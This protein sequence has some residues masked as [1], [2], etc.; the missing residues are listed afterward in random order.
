MERQAAGFGSGLRR[1]GDRFHRRNWVR[2]K[3]DGWRQ[4]KQFRHKI[5][6]G[7]KR[8]KPNPHERDLK[9]KREELARVLERLQDPDVRPGMARAVENG[10]KRAEG[11]SGLPCALI[12]QPARSPHQRASP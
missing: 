12:V 6:E 10:D 1:A 8:S 3:T 11:S 4:A 2:V 7:N 9:K 5:F